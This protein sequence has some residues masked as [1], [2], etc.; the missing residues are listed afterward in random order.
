[1][2]LVEIICLV[3]DFRSK[4]TPGSSTKSRADAER[5]RDS[6]P[7]QIQKPAAVSLASR[8]G[9]VFST[10]NLRVDVSDERNRAFR[11]SQSATSMGL[12]QVSPLSPISPLRLP[13][14][15]SYD[16]DGVP[17]AEAINESLRLSQFPIPP[18][19]VSPQGTHTLP[20]LPFDQVVKPAQPAIR[21]SVSRGSA[22]SRKAASRT[23]CAAVQPV[24][25]RIQEP[26]C[27]SSPRPSASFRGTFHEN[28]EPSKG[29]AVYEDEG[30]EDNPRHSI[31]LYSMRISHHLRSGS[32]LSWEQLADAPELPPTSRPFRDWTL[33]D[34]SRISHVNKQLARHERQ[35]SSSGFASSKVPSKWGKVLPRDYD[36][37][38]DMA[39]SIYSSRPQSPPDSF[40]ASS[41]SLR[42]TGTGQDNVGGTITHSPR[43]RRSNSSP[44]DNEDTPRAM[45]RRGPSNLRAAQGIP[46][47]DSLLITPF[48]LARKNSVADTKKS[49]FR[50]DFSLSPPRKRITPSESIMK[51]LTPKRLSTRSQSEASLTPESPIRTGDAAFDTLEV[52]INKG[53]RQSQ[54]IISLQTEQGALGKQKGADQVWTQALKAHQEDKASLFLP[55]NRDLAAH[56]SPFRERSGSIMTRHSANEASTPVTP[57]PLNTYGSLFAPSFRASF[58][59]QTPESEEHSRPRLVSRRSAMASA[60]KEIP[61]REVSIAFEKQGD[62]QDVVGAWGRYPSH[63][64]EERTNSAG[65]ADRVESRDF[66]LEAAIK[67]ASPQ[68]VDDDLIDP[69]ERIPSMPLMPG[70]RKRKKKVGSGRMA[71]S[72]SMTFGKTFLKNYSKI[73][74][75]SSSEFRKHGR[76]HRSS[77]AAG[78]V[79]EF[80]ELE[81]L[82]EVWKQG[83]SV[84]GGSDRGHRREDSVARRR[85]SDSN[86]VGKSQMHDSMATLR[87]RRNSSAPNLSELASYDGVEEDKH[88]KDNA[89]VWSVYYDDCVPSYPRA[90]AEIDSGLEDFGGSAR[91]SFESRHPSM[92]S[93]TMPAR[94]AMHSRNA[95]GVSRNSVI[96]RE[97]ARP[98]LTSRAED[99]DFAEKRSMVSVRRSTM[100]LITKFKEQEV[101][102]RERVLS[103]TRGG[104]RRDY[105]TLA[106]L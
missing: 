18:L 56:A 21:S 93:R 32:L 11:R 7:Y 37:R 85:A 67:F 19:D 99:D 25:I 80:P 22:S 31:H 17:W 96:S 81:I 73:F 58:A 29:E 57:E 89:R 65:K 94:L 4:A 26:T 44:T 41:N 101:I 15:T 51:F 12:P 84:D 1:M 42:K 36:L 59:P 40:V 53:R 13:S 35:T 76:N 77:I 14:L 45:P 70:E 5:N 82:P 97:S 62:S 105:E 20:V 92:H 47:T 86:D 68:D 71:K 60:G 3:A 55:K 8:V 33:S 69:T 46:R 6:Q 48:P 34:Q 39:S 30:E 52:P 90:S 78:G 98:S 104:S 49:K 54:S 74:K 38:G 88:A 43:A 2:K 100:D 72:N 75:S 91:F 10:P 66:A 79:L 23:P 24:E 95:S 50:E 64:R 16:Q 87:P 61:G 63:T 106:A 28:T 27:V 102:E 83:P 103:I 9:H